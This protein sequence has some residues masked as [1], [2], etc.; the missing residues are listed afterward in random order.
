LRPVIH[1][2]PWII[3]IVLSENGRVQ[4]RIKKKSIPYPPA[5]ALVLALEWFEQKH[6]GQCVAAIR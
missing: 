3:S 1:F 6:L 5:L 2:A 4:C